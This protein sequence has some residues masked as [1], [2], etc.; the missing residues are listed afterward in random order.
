LVSPAAATDSRHLSRRRWRAVKWTALLVVAVLIAAL[1]AFA[2]EEVRTS[3]LQA[4]HFARLAKE[5]QYRVEPGPSR[6][7][8]FPADGPFDERLG[9]SLLPRFVERLGSK[10]YVVEAQARLSP[11]LLDLTGKG[12][13]APYQEKAQAGLS[14]LDCSGGPMFSA[15]HP[16][17]VY[18]RFQDI[19]P[20]AIE[21]LLFIENRELLDT[22]FPTRNP[23]VEWTRLGKAVLSKAVRFFKADY[24]VP[25]GSTLATQI[26]KY[27]HS[28]EGIT[29]TVGEKLRQMVSASLRA[30]R[31]GE[32]TLV[33][34]RHLVLDYLNT[35][36]LSA[37]PGYGEVNGLG[38]GLWAWYGADFDE[39]NRLLEEAKSDRGDLRAQAR[40]YRQVLSLM[41]AHRRPSYLL[42]N[43]RKQLETLTDS[44]L[45][46]LGGAGVIT[47]ELRDLALELRP[48]FRDPRAESAVEPTFAD[49]TAGVV[50]GRLSSL[51]DLPVYSIDR[52]DLTLRSSLDREMQDTVT[53]FLRQLGDARYARSA[54][55]TGERLLTDSSKASTVYYSFTLFERDGDANY[56]RVQTDNSDRPLDINEGTKLELGSTAKLRTLANYLEI[57]A[58]LHQQYAELT[59]A[60]LK[61]ADIDRRDSLSRWAVDYLAKAKDRSLKAMLDAALERRYSANPGEAFFTGGG[62]HSFANFNRGD[63]LGNPSVRD[64][65]RNSVNLA[66]I[67]IMRDV[68]RYYMYQ[69]GSTARVLP[70][71]DDAERAAYLARFADRE[72][73]VFLQRFY[74]KYRGKT[75]DELLETLVGGVRPTAERLAVIFRAVKPEADAKAL[76]AFI[77]EHS[78]F[79]LSDTALA[80]LY[81]RHAPDKFSLAD[82]GYL[83]RVHPLELWLVGYLRQHPEAAWAQVVEAGAQARQDVYKWLFTT[84]H[85][86]AQNQRIYSLLEVEAFEEIHRQWKRLGYPFERLVPSLATAIG[87]SG[88]RPAALAEL[89]GII[90]NDGVRLPTVRLDHFHFAADTPYETVL[91][92]APGGGERVMAPEVAAALRSALA[93]VVKAG[94]AR[95]LYGA[96]DR[97]ATAVE[98]GGKTGTGDNRM[99]SYGAH[100]RLIG[101][102]ARSRTATFVFYIG[103]RHFGVLTAFV[104]GPSAENYSFTSAL[105][106]QILRNMAPRIAPYLD[107]ARPRRC[108]SDAPPLV[109]QPEPPPVAAPRATAAVIPAAN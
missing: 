72:G 94:T 71:G 47:P 88:D 42:A 5:L 12:Y 13:F 37:L 36:P 44:Y 50:R 24:D 25:G 17:R 39:V 64:A 69:P 54:G 43:G 65:L 99:E 27:R 41:V 76:A 21:T 60:A 38:D 55:L 32:E 67:R 63:G 79:D 19:P 58:V 51:L 56:V 23:A 48:A 104:T 1:A 2:T 83:A 8:H 75:R 70:E 109:A 11:A 26:E 16:Q 4:Q 34:R 14:I 73:K 31:Q 35:V 87:S 89:M 66:F 45:R 103:R 61:Q 9:Y 46:L 18:G 40:A 29:T 22:Q 108:A 92:H 90:A 84:R 91:R 95:R 85:R 106:V 107:P 86:G 52:L 78:E 10:D 82:Q 7:I 6:A 105:P 98:I 59:P 30:Y 97:G 15:R 77:D 57:V 53:A 33:S 96:F 102:R 101:S 49:K 93:G 100:G 28:P 20:L 81:E 62:L 3:R 68:V 80:A 74:R